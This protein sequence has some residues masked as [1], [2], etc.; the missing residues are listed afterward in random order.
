MAD[1]ANECVEIV[2]S[3]LAAH[4]MLCA[5]EK[6]L[7]AV[8]GGPD[9][10]CLMHVL[11][12]AGIEIEVAYF[13]HQTRAGESAADAA[14]VRDRA[15]ALRLPFHT[16]SRAARKRMKRWKGRRNTCLHDRR[17]T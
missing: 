7:A 8:S 2:R 16:E 10:M 17:W 1:P 6:T 15:E 12:E 3:T 9:S 4:E 11:Y 14:F 13:D 5:G